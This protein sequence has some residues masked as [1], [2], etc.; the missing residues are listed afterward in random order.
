MS[1]SEEQKV[2]SQ[3]S[4]ESRTT[5]SFMPRSIRSML[6]KGRSVLPR[7]GGLSNEPVSYARPTTNFLK[8]RGSIAGAGLLAK[9]GSLPKG[10]SALIPGGGMDGTSLFKMKHYD[11]YEPIKESPT[12]ETSE[13]GIVQIKADLSK[14]DKETQKRA[15]E[16]ALELARQRATPIDSFKK[17]FLKADHETRKKVAKFLIPTP[18]GPA[19]G[20]RSYR[21][22]FAM[23]STVRETESSEQ[24][25]QLQFDSS[26]SD[27]ELETKGKNRTEKHDSSEDES[28]QK[29]KPTKKTKKSSKLQSADKKM[30]GGDDESTKKQAPAKKPLSD[31][32]LDQAVEDLD[33]D[34]GEAVKAIDY[35]AYVSKIN[36]II[37]QSDGIEKTFDPKSPN[38]I[39]VIVSKEGKVH[40]GNGT[41][42]KSKLKKVGV[43]PRGHNEVKVFPEHEMG[44]AFL[45]SKE[46]LT[47]VL[48]VNETQLT[49]MADLDLEKRLLMLSFPDAPGEKQ[50]KNNKQKKDDSDIDIEDIDIEDKFSKL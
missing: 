3:S 27:A 13:G 17:K 23:E 28:V 10:H 14:V 29:L 31:K 37:N 24:P 32:E 25:K 8:G 11:P 49:N 47:K 18:P 45:L 33:D 48:G 38:K 44:Q 5:D 36:G 12:I 30:D 42:M 1:E 22:N 46:M 19:A 39:W 34:L 4:S 15:E 7:G 20:Q 40:K 16:E 21:K 43:I 35:D 26:G 2:E 50:K 6:P 9:G 41:Q